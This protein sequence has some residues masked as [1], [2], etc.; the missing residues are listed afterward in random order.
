M[1]RRIKIDHALLRRDQSRAGKWGGEGQGNQGT[2]AHEGNLSAREMLS[3]LAGIK[4]A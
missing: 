3:R 1:A 4:T 2:A